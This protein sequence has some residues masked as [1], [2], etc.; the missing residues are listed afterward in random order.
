MSFWKELL[1][2]RVTVSQL[3][4]VDEKKF[5]SAGLRNLIVEIFNWDSSQVT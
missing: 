2:G 5:K 1:R 4:K 3:V